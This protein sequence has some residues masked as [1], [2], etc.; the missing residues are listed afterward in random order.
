[1]VEVCSTTLPQY[2]LPQIYESAEYKNYLNAR[3]QKYKKRAV[4]A[5]EILSKN[6]YLKIIKPK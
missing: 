2:V 4:Q 3:I 1:M 5:E 6:P